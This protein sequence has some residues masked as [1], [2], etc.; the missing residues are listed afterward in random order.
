[1]SKLQSR[2][3]IVY[4][5]AAIG[6]LLTLYP[7]VWMVSTSLK[8]QTEVF[9]SGLSLLPQVFSLSGFERAFQAA[10]VGRFLFNSLFVTVITTIGVA[11]TSIFAGYALGRLQF[12]GRDFIF[13]LILGTMM[14]P[15]QATMIP[16]YILL[17]WFG[18]INE[19]KALIIPHM[20]YPFA[21]FVI[22]NFLLSLPKEL[23]EA[24]MIDGCSRNQ[25]LFRIILPNIKPALATVV[26]F[27]FTYNWNDF[28]YPLVMTKT[29]EMRTAQVGL[30]V[31]KSQFPMEWPML[32]AATVLTSIP[33][34][35][36]YFS[37]QRFFVKGVVGSAVKG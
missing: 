8:N 15:H 33:V 34:F 20:V 16:S 36:I 29:N 19:Y 4:I 5:I 7:Y 28:F 27:T 25:T 9:T 1:M 31:L 32:M 30:A 11:F 18:W 21:I 3:G 22:R 6:A 2:Y 26:I 24:A 13:L 35:L 12:K 23:E 17:N 37:F 14:I 10:P